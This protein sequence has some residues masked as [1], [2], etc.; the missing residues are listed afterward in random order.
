MS[1]C[2]FRQGLESQNE[3][4]SPQL[5]SHHRCSEAPLHLCGIESKNQVIPTN[6]I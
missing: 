6:S 1:F 3:F 5:V 4:S 2:A